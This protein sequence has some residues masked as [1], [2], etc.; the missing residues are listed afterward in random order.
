[1]RAGFF[2]LRSACSGQ[3]NGPTQMLRG[4]CRRRGGEP[5]AMRLQDDA[6]DL[7]ISDDPMRAKTLRRLILFPDR[8]RTMNDANS[9]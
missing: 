6:Q 7:P 9:S 2:R 8:L 1:M 4:E 3:R 5:G